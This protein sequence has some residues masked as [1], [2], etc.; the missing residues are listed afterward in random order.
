LLLAQQSSAGA[1]HYGG[2]GGPPG[3]TSALR[4]GGS[5][6]SGR[7]A[8]IDRA[9]RTAL[10][11][12]EG[13]FQAEWVSVLGDGRAAAASAGGGGATARQQQRYL[14]GAGGLSRAASLQRTEEGGGGDGGGGSSAASSKGA[15]AQAPAVICRVMDSQVPLEADLEVSLCLSLEPTA[16]AAEALD[17]TAA[18]AAM[19]T[20]AAPPAS[21]RLASLSAGRALSS[22][23]GP[24]PVLSALR[25]V[26]LPSSGGVVAEAAAAAAAPAAQW[27]SSLPA[28]PTADTFEQPAGGSGGGGG[29]TS[30]DD[31][32]AGSPLL[33]GRGRGGSRLSS[34][35]AL[36]PRRAPPPPPPPLPLP[37]PLPV[38]LVSDAH[39]PLSPARIYALIFGRRSAAFMARLHLAE[40][41]TDVC[42]GPWERGAVVVGSSLSGSSGTSASLAGR[43]R[44]AVT[45]TRPLAIPLPFAPKSCRI[46]EEQLLLGFSGRGAAGGF[47]AEIR[48]VSD[49]P[50]GD[51][52]VVRVQ[53]AAVPALGCPEASPAAASHVRATLSVDFSRN[54]LGR[55]VIEASAAG[56]SRRVYGA[57]LAALRAEAEADRAAAAEAAAAEGAA[58]VA[59]PAAMAQRFS[60]SGDVGGA[61]MAA[62]SATVGPLGSLSMGGSGKQP[63]AAA[64]RPTLASRLLRA[65]LAGG[66][67]VSSSSSSWSSLAVASMLVRL[68]SAC[69]LTWVLLRV[70]GELREVAE[71]L[72]QLAA[73]ISAAAAAGANAADVGGPSAAA[74]GM[75]SSSSSSSP[76]IALA[77]AAAGATNLG[78][79]VFS[80]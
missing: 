56:D 20:T 40:G 4:S 79:G 55:G 32:F 30:T 6:S 78:A 45:Y 26:G 3:L 34:S 27:S 28:T 52:F 13:P 61:G 7:W 29:S 41:L 23:R 10:R 64:G 44:R 12:G 33:P 25:G 70:V 31:E 53:L 77:L 1:Y 54:V 19:A 71:G 50:R 22:S 14:A 49:A 73:A 46:T 51:T 63:T 76:L 60:S 62:A 69:L 18:A 36:V 57:V 15:F 2:G 35:S 80:P 16:A 75:S 8:E 43:R 67:E 9:V 59:A 72:R 58:G 24:S 48:A 65:W 37:A 5:F 38:P 11:P 17:G 21:R 68:L 66:G 74:A 39:L 42:V 47:V